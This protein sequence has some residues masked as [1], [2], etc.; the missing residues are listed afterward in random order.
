MAMARAHAAHPVP[1]IDTVHATRAAH[2]SM[3]NGKNAPTA[4]AQRNDLRPRLHA[5]PLLGEHE[6]TAGE[7]L[8]GLR[9][10]DRDLQW[11]D[12]LTVEILMQAVVVIRPILKQ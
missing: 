10:E 3:M 7:I 8:A 12:M 4:R 11:E 2:R 6:F 1:Q 5:R 9:Q